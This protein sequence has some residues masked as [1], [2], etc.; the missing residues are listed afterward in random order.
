[1]RP[2]MVSKGGSEPMSLGSPTSPK[3]GPGAQFLPGF[4]MGDLPAPASPQPRSF[5]LSAPGL[6]PRTPLHSAGSTPQPILHTPKDKSGAPPARSIYDDLT[7]SGATPINL[8]R[9]PFTGFQ[10]PMSGHQA[11]GSVGVL[12]PAQVDPFYSQ[13]EALSSE[14][15]LDQTWV[16][17]FGFPPASASYI[18]LQFSQYGNILHHTMSSPGNWMHLQYQSK[19]QARKALSKDGKVFGDCIMVGVK[20]CIDKSVMEGL[21]RASTTSSVCTP[22]Q[23]PS[24]PLHLSSSHNHSALLPSTPRSSMRPLSA[25]YKASSSDYQ[26]VADKLTPRKDDTFVSKAMEYMFGW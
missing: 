21:D 16:T 12:S 5:S 9:Q 7:A 20:P 17:V 8:Y 14:D 15:Q 25:A 26:V 1:M 4:L 22:H 11:P 19:L 18:L 23:L 6:E 24:T 10:S 13:G 2:S 3:P